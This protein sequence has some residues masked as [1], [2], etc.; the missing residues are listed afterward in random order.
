MMKIINSVISL[1]TEIIKDGID[2]N[3][4]YITDAEKSAS[5]LLWIIYGLCT[6]I[7]LKEN[8]NIN[9]EEETD[10]VYNLFLNGIKK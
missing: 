3:K 4:F 5:A 9:V 8:G 7:T 10:F 2:N 6:N 1:L